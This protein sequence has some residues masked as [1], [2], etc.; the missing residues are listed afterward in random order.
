M[1]RNHASEALPRY[2]LHHQCEQRLAYVHAILRVLET[3]KHRKTVSADSNRGHPR[4]AENHTQYCTYSP[5]QTNEP[6]TSDLRYVFSLFPDC[7][8]RS[9][10]AVPRRL[11]P[12][13]LGDFTARLKPCPA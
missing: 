12:S 11:K 6:D 13:G 9:L 2:K 8:N 10:N 4:I 7:T 1:F 5:Q 3:R